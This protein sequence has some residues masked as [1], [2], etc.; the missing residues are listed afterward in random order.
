MVSPQSF[1]AFTKNCVPGGP[2]HER[3]TMR[4]RATWSA[5][6]ASKQQAHSMPRAAA[7]HLLL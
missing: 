7:P 2:A 3:V 5:P 4:A 6:E 1:L